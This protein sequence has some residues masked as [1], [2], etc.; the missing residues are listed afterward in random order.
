LV[1]SEDPEAFVVVSETLE[2]MGQR[3]GNQPHW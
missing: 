3:V 1:R 2:V